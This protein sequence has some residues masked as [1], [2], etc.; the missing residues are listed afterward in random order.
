MDIPVSTRTALLQALIDN[1]GY[2]KD[3]IE[4][5][6]KTTKNVIELSIG[7]VYPALRSLE[8]EGLI[9]RE[10]MTGRASI[11]KL[12]ADGKKSLLKDKKAI[13]ALFKFA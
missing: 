10:S 8:T 13:A 7:S 6:K 5:V 3:L 12:T 1:P 4:R 2:G 9:V 11:F